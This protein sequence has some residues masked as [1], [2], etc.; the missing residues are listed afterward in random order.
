MG[1]GGWGGGGDATTLPDLTEQFAPPETAPPMLVKLLDTI[2]R[3]EVQSLEECA[4]L[5]KGICGSP[6]VPPQY[7][8]TL[9]C[10]IKHLG[11]VCQSAAKNQLSARTLG[12]IFSPLLFR[13]Q[14]ASCEPSP[15]SHLKIIE[16]LISSELSES[17]AAPGL[18]AGPSPVR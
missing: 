13:H 6:S 5:L 2:E 17:Q 10:L 18:S 11:R 8:L 16:V 3:R 4:Q 12:E 1:D 14:A 9:H 7:W 15:D